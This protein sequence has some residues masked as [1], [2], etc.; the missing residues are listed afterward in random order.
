MV[1]S[2]AQIHEGLVLWTSRQYAGRGMGSTT[3]HSEADKN[4]TSSFLFKPVFL[5]PGQQFTLNKCIAV[6]ICQA[7]TDLA[8]GCIFKIK[9]PN[10]IYF[11]SK[12][13]A[14]TLIENRIMGKTFEL[15]VAGIGININ[16]RKFPEDIPNPTSLSCITGES[17][18]L[19]ACLESLSNRIYLGYETLKSGKTDTI[20]EQYLLHLLGMGEE[21]TFAKD[22]NVFKGRITGV[23]EYGHLVVKV[24]N[25]TKSF[26]M[27][28]ISY[29]F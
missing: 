25:T 7:L 16:Q 21:L 5:E 6:A 22:D 8:P 12:K 18:N 3:W 17:Y 19:K 23:N 27:K 20:N 14:G 29:V 9:W 13:I 4:L 11:E 26:E 10:D 1:E 28:E 15:C 2:G 24:N